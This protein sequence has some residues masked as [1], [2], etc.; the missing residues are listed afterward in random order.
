MFACY[1][2]LPQETFL[3][4]HRIPLGNAVYRSASSQGEQFH[5]VSMKDVSKQQR[6]KY[7]CCEEEI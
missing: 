3:L 1:L 7:K 6:I 4:K 2:Q 5:K